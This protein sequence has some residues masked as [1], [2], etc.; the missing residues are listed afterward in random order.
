MGKYK[1]KSKPVKIPFISV[2]TPTF[3]RRP[4]IPSMIEC[5]NHQTYP[6]DKI[7]WLILD[8]G[9]DKIEDLVKDIPQVRYIRYEE[10]LTLG[11]KRNILNS[12]AKGEIII[13]MDD[14]DYYPP[15]RFTHAVEKLRKSKALCA[16]SSEMYIYF[17]HISKMYKFGPYGPNHATAATFAFKRELLE[18]TCFDENASLAEEKKFLKDYSIPFIQL[19]PLKTILVFSHIHN[20]FDKKEL[21]QQ[22]PSP[23]VHDC[24]YKPKD[25][26]KQPKLLE[27]YMNVDNL[28]NDYDFG[29]TKHKPDVLKQ[30]VE[31]KTARDK[32]NQEHVQQQMQ[33][34]ILS[35]PQ[36]IIDKL[37]EQHNIILKLINE[38]N[39]LKQ[40]LQKVYNLLQ[41]QSPILINNSLSN[42]I[43]DN[44]NDNTKTFIKLNNQLTMNY[45]NGPLSYENNRQ[46]NI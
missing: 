13:Y 6:K 23:F 38:N 25:F 3:N 33:Q 16:G 4:F 18:Q 41:N 29:S 1:N 46:P 14:D 5:F 21:L 9:S 42:N 2:L 30:L 39:Q 44:I 11:K 37:N 26:I 20:T 19:D 8:D 24:D 31:I 34:N 45:S 28:L 40:E 22:L 10:K 32:M 36:Q 27:F 17:K 12:N 15:E 35:N 43:N 7:E